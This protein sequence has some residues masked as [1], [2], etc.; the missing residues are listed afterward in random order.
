MQ[1]TND[2]VRH[3]RHSQ[4]A[5]PLVASVFASVAVTILATF[6]VVVATIFSCGFAG[7]RCDGTNTNETG[8][9]TLAALAA[10]T[11]AWAAT[12]WVG[13]ARRRDT[14]TRQL[15]LVGIAVP[16]VAGAAATALVSLAIF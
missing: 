3:D 2:T 6:L 1:T 13:W 4:R 16:A 7:G 10:V 11:A 12:A 14:L 15:Y 9:A 8:V 5:A